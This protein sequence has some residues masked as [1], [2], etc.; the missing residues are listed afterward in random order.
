LI[1]RLL[2]IAALTDAS[3]TGLAKTR[4]S[5]TR[6][7]DL[8]GAAIA[9]V[10]LLLLLFAIAAAIV[11][12]DTG[13]VL[14]RSR[15]YGNDRKTFIVRRFRTTRWAPSTPGSSRRT[16]VG[17]ALKAYGLD[18]L[19]LLVNVITGEMSLI[20]SRSGAEARPS[21]RDRSPE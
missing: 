21:A 12:T 3:A 17:R 2:G 9:L 1:S 5:V 8:T 11:A 4:K 15:K 14:V 6:S 19:P 18:E 16:V 13:P 7:L 20:G 10:L